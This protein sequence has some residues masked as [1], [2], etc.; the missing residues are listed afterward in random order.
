MLYILPLESLGEYLCEKA[1]MVY[2]L[3]V[4]LPGRLPLV[5]PANCFLNFQIFYP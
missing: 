2:V 4:V 1:A 5:Y 3:L